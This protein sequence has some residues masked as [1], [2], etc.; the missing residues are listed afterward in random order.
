MVKNDRERLD[1]F[2]R[3]SNIAALPS[4]VERYSGG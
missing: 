3:T 4:A 1:S 2:A